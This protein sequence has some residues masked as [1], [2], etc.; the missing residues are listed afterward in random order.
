MTTGSHR[1][2][3]GLVQDVSD[4]VRDSRQIKQLIR[5]QQAILNSNIVGFVKLKARRFV[6]SQ[7]SLPAD[8]RLRRDR[9][10]RPLHPPHL[11][12]PESLRNPR[13]GRL[14]HHAGRSDLPHRG[15]ADAWDGSVGWYRLDGGGLYRAA[16]NPSG[17]S[18]T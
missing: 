6:W 10:P 3:I 18:S 17:P 8:A 12:R 2:L 14:R 9:T 11:P 13:P 7:R 4:R 1:S 16:T 5:E 15:A